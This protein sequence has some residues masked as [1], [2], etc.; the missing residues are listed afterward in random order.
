MMN[1]SGITLVE[2]LVVVVVMGIIAVVAGIQFWN[3]TKK[4]DV[5]SDIKTLYANLM[6]ARIKAFTE[7]TTYGI[8]WGNAP[9]TKYELRKDTDDDGDITDET[10]I[11]EIKLERELTRTGSASSIVF[12]EKGTAKAPYVTIYYND[13]TITAEYTCV[14][15]SMTRIKMGKW[16]GSNCKLK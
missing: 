4:H 13:T 8:Y 9:F 2:I 3:I 10:S 1:K 5:E 12:T 14:V 16:D 7:N 11:K 15:V 6:E